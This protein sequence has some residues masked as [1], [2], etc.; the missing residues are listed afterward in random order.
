M[1]DIDALIERLINAD[2][3][4]NFA[5]RM[6]HNILAEGEEANAARA[7]LRAALHPPITDAQVE[8]GKE[9]TF[10]WLEAWSIPYPND[11]TEFV[12][13]LVT[14]APS[15]PVSITV[16]V[17]GN[18]SR[19]LAPNR[20]VSKLHKGRDVAELREAAMYA[21]MESAD[22]MTFT[23]PVSLSVLVKWAKGERSKDLD[24]VAVMCK[25]ALDGLVDAEIMRNDSQV[26]RLTVCQ[27]A[28][29]VSKIA[30]GEIVMTVEEL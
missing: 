20:G 17:P 1:S 13:A 18:P 30:Q 29:R 24:S 28:Y 12:R 11:I 7:A 14:A 9:L 16:V 5:V 26:K 22:G 27:E 25:P 21:G 23:G 15:E 19:R 2:R 6:K 3:A 8:A 10:R 4:Y